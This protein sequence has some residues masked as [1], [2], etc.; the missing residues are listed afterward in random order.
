MINVVL[1]GLSS[2]THAHQFC[3][4]LAHYLETLSFAKEITIEYSL[5]DVTELRGYMFCFSQ[6][7]L[8][9][10]VEKPDENVEK[11]KELLDRLAVLHEKAECSFGVEIH[12]VTD[13]IEFK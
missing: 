2:R 7:R 6:I 13:F 11:I 4:Q 9:V 5:S 8:R 3:A 12:P 1:H 10:Y